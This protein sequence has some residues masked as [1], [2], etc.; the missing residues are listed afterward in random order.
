MGRFITS[1]S[2]I[3]QTDLPGYWRT[4]DNELYLD[5]DS[6]L[7]LVPRYFWSDGYTFPGWVMAILGDKQKWDV[8]PAHG[9]DSFCRFHERIRVNMSLTNLKMHNY[10]HEHKDK[11]VCEDI[12]I[13]YLEIERIPKRW[14]DDC[15]KRMMLSTESIPEKT[16][17]LIRFGVIFNLNWY[18]KTGKKSI[19]EYNI[20]NEDIGLVNGV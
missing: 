17:N 14:A 13:E 7:Y 15:F 19:L 4:L 10:I 12:P 2:R 3:E 8:R 5:D 11:I 1:K 16:I 9:H 18:L 20:Y 6:T